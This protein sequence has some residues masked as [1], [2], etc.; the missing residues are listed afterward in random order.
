MATTDAEK[1]VQKVLTPKTTPNGGLHGM[2]DEVI[3]EATERKLIRKL[4][5]WIVPPGECSQFPF[6]VF[7]KI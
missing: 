2:T 7:G 4:D 6:E 1:A 3:D 5:M